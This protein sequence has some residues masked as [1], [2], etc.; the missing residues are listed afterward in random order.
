MVSEITKLNVYTFRLRNLACK[1]IRCSRE[2]MKK[3]AEKEKKDL[4]SPPALVSRGKDDD[5]DDDCTFQSFSLSFFVFFPK[6]LLLHNEKRA[7]EKE[8][9]AEFGERAHPRS[10]SEFPRHRRHAP[11]SFESLVLHRTRRKHHRAARMFEEVEISLFPGKHPKASF[12]GEDDDEERFV[13]SFCAF[14]ESA[15]D[16]VIDARRQTREEHF[17]RRKQLEEWETFEKERRRE[18]RGSRE[19]Q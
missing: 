1:R 12:R 18:G 5:D 11:H 10:S 13:V 7:R 8:T 14:G 2:E 6:R 9:R 17:L 16:D 4:P 15:R 3:H 19:Q